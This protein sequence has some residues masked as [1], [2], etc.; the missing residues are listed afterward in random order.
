MSIQLFVGLIE[1][2]FHK[3]L[4]FRSRMLQHHFINQMV[5]FDNLLLVLA[6]LFVNKNLTNF[7]S[8][9]KKIW[10]FFLGVILLGFFWGPFLLLSKHKWKQI[11]RF[12]PMKIHSEMIY[13][14]ALVVKCNESDKRLCWGTLMIIYCDILINCENPKKHYFILFYFYLCLAHHQ[15]FFFF[16]KSSFG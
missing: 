8:I 12:V 4:P 13:V 14:Q 16:F 5:Q 15:C 3:F 9:A 7:F 11:Q 6:M 10:E 2:V 1:L